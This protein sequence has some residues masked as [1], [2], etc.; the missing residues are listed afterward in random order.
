MIDKIYNNLDWVFGVA[1]ILLVAALAYGLGSESRTNKLCKQLGGVYVQ[2]WS[3][4][5][6]CIM[7]TEISLK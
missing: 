4:G 3:D 2:T 5:H 1:L 6:T 7:A